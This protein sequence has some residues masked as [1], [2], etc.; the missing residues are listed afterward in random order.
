MK[1]INLLEIK[2]NHGYKYFKLF[3]GDITKINFKIDLLCVSAYKNGYNPVKGTVLGSL[4]ENRDIDLSILSRDPEIELRHSENTFITKKLDDTNIERILCIEM[5]GTKFGSIEENINSLLISIYKAQLLGIK[6]KSIMLPLLGTGNQN[7]N[8]NLVMEVLIKKMEYLLTTSNT[9]EEVYLVEFN[10]EKCDNLNHAMNQILG[11]KSGIFKSGNVIAT[12]INNII[13]MKNMH[14][15]FFEDKAFIDLISE[16]RSDAINTT[17]L[18]IYS[19]NFCE[20]IMSKIF[21]DKTTQDLF[22][23]IEKLKSMN[24]PPWIVSYFHLLRVYGNSHVH[25]EL[26][27]K[28][29]TEISESDLIIVLFAIERILDFFIYHYKTEIT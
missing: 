28:I 16:L 14:V 23:M 8:P 29:P 27:K 24:I 3:W 22:T 25:N 17:L 10:Q 9:V 7:L 1:L 21:F 18:S 19:R 13:D 4:Y 26:R 11:R 15:D 12:V 20:A 2:S 5:I 6:F